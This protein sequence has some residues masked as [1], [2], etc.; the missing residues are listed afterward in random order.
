ML[1]IAALVTYWRMC[2]ID[3]VDDVTCP[4]NGDRSTLL[5]E[6]DGHT[7]PDPKWYAI[8]LL[9]DIACRL[10]LYR[11]YDL[12]AVSLAAGFVGNLFLLFNFTGRVRYMI[13]LPVTIFTWYLAAGIVSLV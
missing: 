6:L 8:Q 7:F 10:T 1:S 2:L 5:P 13:A 11:C 12:N 9:L 4:W 3:G